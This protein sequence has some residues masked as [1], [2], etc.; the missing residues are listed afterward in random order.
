[1]AASPAARRPETGR[2]S[3]PPQ[4]YCV[5][6]GGISPAGHKAQTMISTTTTAITTYQRR[7]S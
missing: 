4:T 2:K 7:L 1:M 3:G 6:A 5:A